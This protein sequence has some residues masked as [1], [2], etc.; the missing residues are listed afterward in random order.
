MAILINHQ[1]QHPGGD[2]VLLELAG[3]DATEA[4]DDQNHSKDAYVILDKLFIGELHQ[5]IFPHVFDIK[6]VSKRMIGRRKRSQS[7][8]LPRKFRR[9]RD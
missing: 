2:E 1:L 7:I 6:T 4:F 3:K 5:V 9:H 8:L